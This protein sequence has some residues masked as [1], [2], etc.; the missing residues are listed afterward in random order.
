MCLRRNVPER[1]I[2]CKFRR[3]YSNSYL[4]KSS[5]K[6]TESRTA[7]ADF[8]SLVK[9]SYIQVVMTTQSERRGVSLEA[10]AF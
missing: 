4:R 1:V 7:V 10:A 3:T 9:N 5:V 2:V 8:N 6:F